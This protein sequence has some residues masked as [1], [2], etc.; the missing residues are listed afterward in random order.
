MPKQEIAELDDAMVTEAPVLPPPELLSFYTDLG[1]R[2]LWIDHDLSSGDI[3]YVKYILRWNR[4]DVGVPMANRVP[5][6]IMLFTD[7]GDLNV[8][9]ALVDAIAASTTPVY[10]CNMG[11]AYSAGAL[12]FLACHRRLAMPNS[13]LLLHKGHIGLEGTI[14]EVSAYMKRQSADT[15]WMIDLIAESSNLSR[16]FVTQKLVNDWFVDA[17]EAAKEYD[18]VDEIIFS[19]DQ[20]LVN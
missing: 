1:D 7:G 15:Q 12:I 6:R 13:A 10:G 2:V 20:A 4:E 16:E 11:K 14:D 3:E 17:K 5:I 8:C 18:M 9:Q 19:L